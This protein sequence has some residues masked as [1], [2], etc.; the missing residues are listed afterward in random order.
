LAASGRLR[1]VTFVLR[2]GLRP[3][4]GTC[5]L[6]DPLTNTCRTP[7]QLTPGPWDVRV[8]R[9]TGQPCEI[10]V[11]GPGYAAPARS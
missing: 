5:G 4:D 2:A 3:C 6:L 9:H 11:C 8:T 10:T 1:T 7:L